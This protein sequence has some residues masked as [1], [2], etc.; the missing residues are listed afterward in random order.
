VAAAAAAVAA[1]AQTA[2]TTQQ[3]M[4]YTIP[5]IKWYGSWFLMIAC[6]F[7]RA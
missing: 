4:K 3:Q 2:S 7:A 5:N 1:A 6:I